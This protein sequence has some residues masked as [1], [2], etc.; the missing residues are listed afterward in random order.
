MYAML[1]T[2]GI[3]SI[4]NLIN[5]LFQ[6]II[7]TPASALLLDKAGKV[8]KVSTLR[9]SIFNKKRDAGKR[10]HTEYVIETTLDSPLR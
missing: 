6:H 5:E 2:N 1:R 7:K 8:N 3:V 4:F 9:L 10:V